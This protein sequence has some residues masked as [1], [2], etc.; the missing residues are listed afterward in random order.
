MSEGV[1][2]T[3]QCY[4]EHY[5]ALAGCRWQWKCNGNEVNDCAVWL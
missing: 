1:S 2:L 3:I 4:E 5:T